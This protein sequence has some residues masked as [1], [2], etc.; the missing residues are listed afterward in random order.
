MTQISL[1]QQLR[2]VCSS[3]RIEAY[4]AGGGDEIDALVLYVWNTALCESLYPSLQN[5]EIGLRNRLND[6]LVKSYND[7][8]WYED[9]AILDQVGLNKIKEAKQTLVDEEKEITS[10]RV[11]AELSFGFWTRLFSVQYSDP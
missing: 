8:E 10:S 3:D 11:I 9:P 7:P 4:Q 5:L 2:D 1:Y 6:A